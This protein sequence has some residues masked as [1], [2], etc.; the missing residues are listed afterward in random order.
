MSHRAHVRLR[1]LQFGSPRLTPPSR[2]HLL[3][4]T[5]DPP[6]GLHDVRRTCTAPHTRRSSPGRGTECRATVH[7][8]DCYRTAGHRVPGLGSID[9]L[10]WPLGRDTVVVPIAQ[11]QRVG[12]RGPRPPRAKRQQPLP[13][14]GV[15]QWR[16]ERCPPA[17]ESERRRAPRYRQR[18]HRRQS[19]RRRLHRYEYLVCPRPPAPR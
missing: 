18:Q 17:G 2:C 16:R 15:G 3:L 10:E 13:L 4:R 1:C 6:R 19:R 5:L 12:A 7:D 14:L 9:L 11:Q 8:C